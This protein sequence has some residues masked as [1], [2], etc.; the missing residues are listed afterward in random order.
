MSELDYKALWQEAVERARL[1]AADMYEPGIARDKKER[2]LR[3][4][5]YRE[6]TTPP[7]GFTQERTTSP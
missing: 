6:Y 2:E 3:Y 4:A 1:T 7:H 5:Y